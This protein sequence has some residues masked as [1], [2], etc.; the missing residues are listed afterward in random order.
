M[1]YDFPKQQYS[2]NCDFEK[3]SQNQHYQSTILVWREG[4]TKK[5]TLCTLLILLIILDDPLSEVH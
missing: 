4:A 5:T 3:G 2:I 1:K